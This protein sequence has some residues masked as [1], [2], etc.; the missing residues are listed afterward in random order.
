[1]NGFDIFTLLRDLGAI[2]I[3]TQTPFTFSSGIQSPIYCDNRVVISHPSAR[4][5]LIDAMIERLQLHQQHAFD[6]IAGTATAGIPHAAWLADR[7]NLPMIYVRAKAKAHGQKNLIE[8]SLHP[9]QRVLVVE[10]LIST[11]QSALNAIQ[12]IRDHGGLV[13]DCISIVSYGFSDAHMAFKHQSVNL[14]QL[15]NLKEVIDS[16]HFPDADRQLL[17]HWHQYPRSWQPA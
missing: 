8:G 16:H 6:V 5:R 14:T 7:L 9:Q 3:N 12:A 17:Q 4:N 1:M 11:G 10:D 15:M 13:T 2:Q